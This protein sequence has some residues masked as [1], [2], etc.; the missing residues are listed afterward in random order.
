M[1]FTNYIPS[2]QDFI[3]LSIS[4]AFSKKEITLQSQCAIKVGYSSYDEYIKFQYFI[5]VCI[6]TNLYF[7]GKIS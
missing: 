1:E 6:Q 2:L 4:D 5:I 3:H 7:L